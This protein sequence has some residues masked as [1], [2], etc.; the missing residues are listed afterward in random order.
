MNDAL[1]EPQSLL[2]V[3]GT[4]E[5]GLATARSLVSR[6]T[7]TVVLAG[8][9]LEALETHAAE[10]R[11]LG[12]DHAEVVAFDADDTDSHAAFV[13]RVFNDHGDI[14]VVLLAFGVLGDQRAAEDQPE[15]AVALLRTNLVGAASV[16]LHVAGHLRGQGHGTLVVLSSVA[17]ERARRSNFVYGASK[18]GMDAFF[19][20]L[21]DSLVGS[22]AKVLVVRPGFVHTK[23]TAGLPPPPISTTPEK[24]AEV[25]VNALRSGAEQVWAPRRL[26]FLMSGVRH[27]PRPLFRRLEV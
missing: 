18:A 25:I 3:G 13:W 15:Q 20:G 22:G 9:R 11:S 8:R 17:G 2:V 16:G 12:A 26:R 10:L 5:I 4:S 24:V 27:L 1:G 6:R 14:D 23:M 19:Q 21:G 7:R